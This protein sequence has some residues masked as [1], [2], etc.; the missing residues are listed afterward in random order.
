MI[1]QVNKGLKGNNT[2]NNC[3][4]TNQITQM[5]WTNFWKYTYLSNLTQ[6]ERKSEQTYN[7]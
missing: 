6:E 7:N 2:V 4:L 3:M 5:K 1:L